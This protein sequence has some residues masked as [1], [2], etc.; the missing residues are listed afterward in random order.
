MASWSLAV[1]EYGL[2]EEVLAEFRSQEKHL[3]RGEEADRRGLLGAARMLIRSPSMPSC[4]P[5][6]Q[7]RAFTGHGRTEKTEQPIFFVG[8]PQGEWSTR[9]S[10]V[11][12][13]RA[14]V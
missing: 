10:I 9:V 4:V 7:V 5:K 11:K 3:P 12:I 1:A 14:H 2:E 13:G 6:I 8:R